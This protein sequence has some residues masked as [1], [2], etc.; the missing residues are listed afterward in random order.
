MP[1][2]H[3]WRS[4][5]E[6]GDYQPSQTR[7]SRGVVLT[8]SSILLLIA[9]LIIW[10]I[11]QFTVSSVSAGDSTPSAITPSTTPDFTPS[12]SASIT[13]TL[14]PTATNSPPP[15]SPTFAPLLS[16]REPTSPLES[17]LVVLALNEAGQSHLFAYQSQDTQY[18]RLTSGPW[19]DTSPAL[20]PDGRWLAFASNRSGPWDIYL[21]DLQSGDLQRLTETLQYEA[22]P[23]WSPDGKLLAYE[24][25]DTDYEIIIQS[26]FDDQTWLNLSQHPAADYQP[27][28]S[29]NGRQLA[30]ISNRT[31]EPEVWL[32]DFDSFDEERFSNLSSSPETAETHPI[33]S[34]DGSSLAWAALEERN[35]SLYIWNP[36][37]GSRYVGSGDWPVW[38]P[39]GSLL[40]ATLHDPNQSLLTAYRSADSMLALPAI[41]LP[42]TA[43][44]LTWSENTLPSPLPAGLL[45]ISLEE[46]QLP[47]ISESAEKNSSINSLA[48]LNGVQAPFPQL[49][50]SVDEAFHALREKVSAEAGW[51]FL[52]T[53]ENAFVPLSAPLGPGMGDDW[54]YTGRAFTFDTLPM[55]GGWVVVVQ[56]IYGHENFWRV[57]VKARFQDGSQ[58]KPMLAVP[59]VFNARYA[60]DPLLYEQGGVMGLG[61]PAGY[62]VD[63]TEMAQ[64]LGWQRLPALPTW[65]SNVFAA[66][67]NEFVFPAGKSWQQAMNVLYPAE[68]LITPT[69]IL[70]PTLTP[71][72]TPSWPIYST[73]TP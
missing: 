54:L 72:R 27:S 24:R 32:A 47:W 45:Q 62:W 61:I 20:S 19:D 50:D 4:L 46:P 34:P 52:G 71:T 13:P 73:P 5:V 55:N 51:D 6:E 38:S 48:N 67:F 21:L 56:E 28:W 63:F 18:L 44:G 10:P 11:L 58:G 35:R 68:Y 59:W 70:P 12:P 41:I 14:I 9:T 29:S 7:I 1:T 36:T 31:G 16:T 22:A 60:G 2:G 65:Q 69:Q 64:S 39:D 42:G 15:L 49:H 26:V 17:G 8:T 66:R 37:Q 25:Y 40:L 43:A 23:T 33:W 57:Y 53:L 30:F 3:E